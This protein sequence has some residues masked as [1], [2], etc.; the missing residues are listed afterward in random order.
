MS[1][2]TVNDEGA[3]QQFLAA[4]RPR[5]LRLC[6]HLTG[7]PDAAEDLAQETLIEAWRHL[8][9]L[10]DPQALPAWLSG[11]ARNVSARRLR[12][13]GREAP[14]AVL[15]AEAVWADPQTS[16]ESDFEAE[17]E[18]DELAL[19]LDRAL[20]LLPATTRAV[21]VQKYI[22]ESSHAAIASALGLSESAVAVRLH[23]GKLAMRALLTGELR[24]EAEQLG[25]LPAGPAYQ[26]TRLW[27]PVCG[28]R[29]LQGR[30]DDEEFLLRCPDCCEEPDA[31]ISQ[32]SYT[33]E[34]ARLSSF[35][36]ALSRFAAWSHD[37]FQGAVAAGS[38]PCQRCG[39]LAPLR[40]GLP[41]YAP[42][43]VRR[44]PGIHVLC[45]H[46][47]SGAYSSLDGVA[48]SAPQA[49]AFWR[50]EQRIR[51]CGQRELEID[52]LPAWGVAFES[53]RGPARIEALIE[54]GTCRVL[55]IHEGAH[56]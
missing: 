42:P 36:P 34:L 6:A 9:Q 22:A 3:F 46:C 26:E 20:A 39:R 35:R 31:V 45:A 10:R 15:P 53:L 27:C 4:E 55:A 44:R 11:I 23:R 1:I 14:L 18:R 49:Q 37:Y 52:G 38:A 56:A 25:L 43:S 16:I 12:A 32:S 50:R 7:E 17:L 41:A 28:R 47:G 5:L 19:L 13:R 8:D 29:R 40:E 48:L 33:G 51:L 30:L 2:H 54:R 24:A 21:L